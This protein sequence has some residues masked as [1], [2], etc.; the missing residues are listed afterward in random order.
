MG[1]V[2]W[3]CGLLMMMG[4]LSLYGQQQAEK[5]NTTPGQ[6]HQR[7]AAKQSA[8]AGQDDADSLQSAAGNTRGTADT[9]GA[10]E[11]AADAN[12]NNGDGGD[13]ASAERA[14]NT[15][16]VSQT[17]SSG[18]GSPAVLSS[19]DGQGRDGTN[20]VQRASM[21][22]AGSP[23]NNIRL[24]QTNSVN[25]DNEMRDRQIVEQDKETSARK[26]NQRSGGSPTGS[27]SGEINDNTRRE[28]NAASDQ[29][30]SARDK[31]SVDQKK[32]TNSERKSK[33]RRN[34]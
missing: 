18:S 10:A 3:I 11:A 15:P 9:P 24:G 31:S 33:R 29:N 34:N 21:N 28:N 6:T 2:K 17:T 25:A 1:K 23:A 27:R 13:D 32:P 26:Q 14:S 20:N 16:A 30:L 8:E 5:K 19:K 12:S 22:M 7:N 4:V